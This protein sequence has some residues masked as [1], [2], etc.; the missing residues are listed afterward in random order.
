[1]QT[2][3]SRRRCVPSRGRSISDERHVQMRD[4]RMNGIPSERRDLSPAEC[5]EKF[6]EMATGSEEGQRWCI[7]AKISFDNP[8][9]AMRDPV[10]YR[11]N[12]LPHHRTG[13]VHSH[14]KTPADPWQGQVQGVPDLRLC[15][16]DCRLLGGRDARVE[17]ERV[18]RQK[19]SVPVDA[20]CT[21]AEEGRGVGFWVR[22]LLAFSALVPV[23]TED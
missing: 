7:R 6:A 3:L 20:G 14:S 16:S 4:E 9:K 19:P 2:T 23:R 1:M 18:P 5:L 17:D 15:V 22:P 21:R 13:Y 10:I 8:N 11:G 12:A